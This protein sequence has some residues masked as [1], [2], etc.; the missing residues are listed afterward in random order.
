M[1][2][3]QRC[4]Q[5]AMLCTATLA[6]GAILTIF[7]G[8]SDNGSASPADSGA[9]SGGSGTGGGTGGGS[10]GGAGGRG[11]GGG[12]GSV[13]SAPLHLYI[14]CNDLTGTIQSYSLNTTTGALKSMAT[15]LAGG[16]VSNAQF[17]S[18][19]DRLYVGHQLNGDGRITTFARDATTGVLSVLGTPVADPFVA[20]TAGGMDASAGTDA[21]SDA[22]SAPMPRYANPQ[23]LTLDHTGRF[24]VVPNY[25]ANDVYVYPIGANGGL[26]ALV[27][28]HSDG[29]FAH[30]AVFTNNNNFVLV[31]YLGSNLIQVYGF[32]A[33]TGAMTLSSTVN[34]P[35]PM[36]GPRHLALHPNGKWLYSINETAGGETTPAGAISSYTVDQ[37]TGAV[38]HTAVFPVPLPVG[39]SGLRTARRSRFDPSGKHLYVSM[40][41]D[42]VA[43]GSIVVY[44][45][46]AT[47]GAL[48]FV[49]QESSRGV[50]PRQFSLS[51]DGT[52]MVV[53]NQNSD[54]VAVFRVDATSGSISFLAQRDVCGPPWFARMASPR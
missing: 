9:G 19:E 35:D 39:Y 53:G 2:L 30:H 50:R 40:R 29:I 21:G 11:A 3:N 31:P 18:A 36:M 1:N 54:N 24:L 43:I 51:K 46:N 14:G 45:I 20:P 23:T 33:T 26:G 28:A 47:T 41:L 10:G 22:A 5:R 38:A 27:S 34:L 44:S 7:A 15:F 17:N 6:T 12:A 32:S 25:D 42:N 49:Q 4:K 8:C 52:M 13:A 16:G 37:S 48:A